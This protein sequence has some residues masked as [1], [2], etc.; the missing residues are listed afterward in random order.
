MIKFRNTLCILLFT[1]T[2]C[3]AQVQ[4]GTA[5]EFTGAS[6]AD[7]AIQGL[8][9]PV[10]DDAAITVEGA[11]LTGG[12]TWCD[13][14]FNAG[15][16]VL[17]ATPTVSV[18]A[19]GLL[20]RFAAPG[21]VHGNLNIQCGSLPA[22]PLQR[23]DGLAPMP[24]QLVAGRIVEV[25][26]ADGRFLLLNAMEAGCPAGF[27][28]A[29]ERICMEVTATPNMLYHDGLARC[30]DMGAKMC[31][32]DEYI[33]GCTALQGQLQNLFA[34]W[35]W[36]DDSSNHAHGAD[37]AGRTTCLSQRHISPIP[38]YLSSVRCCYRPR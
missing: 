37:Q 23:V 29:N 25:L 26:Y 22:V 6:D 31:T 15:T 3:R 11:L 38:T 8:A 7:R 20:L 33:A 5:I 36:L 19:D 4:V 18:Y 27:L 17:Q 12:Y 21:A 13:A 32:W 30:A 10:R 1:A 2:W 24:G 9:A 28:L 14:S 16:L 35:E 34:D